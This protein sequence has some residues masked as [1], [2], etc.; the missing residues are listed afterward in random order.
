MSEP[1]TEMFNAAARELERE[2]AEDPS[3]AVQ[4]RTEGEED[5]HEPCRQRAEHDAQRIRELSA[6]RNND[7]WLWEEDGDNDLASIS[8]ECP[9]LIMPR[10]LERLLAARHPEP[11]GE[12]ETA[13]LL[14]R[15]MGE[16]LETDDPTLMEDTHHWLASRPTPEPRES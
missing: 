5:I 4:R 7:P 14:R 12:G 1:I 2:E 10:T 13:E 8:S 11:T 3:P 9:I 16:V 15:W 6:M